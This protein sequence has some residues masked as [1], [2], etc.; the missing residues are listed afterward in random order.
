MGGGAPGARG[1]VPGRARLGREPGRKPTTHMTTD[2]NPIANQNP[3][4]GETDT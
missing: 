3:K 2:R 1:G 4:R